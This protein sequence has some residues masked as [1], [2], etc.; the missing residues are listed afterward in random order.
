MRLD[1]E[2]LMRLAGGA[3]YMRQVPVVIGA[4]VVAVIGCRRAP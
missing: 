2:F 1:D 3:L 4:V